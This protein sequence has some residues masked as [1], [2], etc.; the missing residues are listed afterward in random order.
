VGFQYFILLSSLTDLDYRVFLLQ[1]GEVGI[2]AIKPIIVDGKCI[3]N[4]E[5]VILKPHS[6]VVLCEDDMYVT[7]VYD[8]QINA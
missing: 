7:A 8:L 6:Q 3:E 2:R 4:Q 1:T 5:I